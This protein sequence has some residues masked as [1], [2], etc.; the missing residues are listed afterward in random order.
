MEQQ[1]TLSDAD[2]EAIVS[3]LEVRITQK[4]YLNVGKGIFHII[5]KYALI[6]A[7]SIA[8][9]GSFKGFK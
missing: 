1:R 2:V 7:L 9:Y 5:W 8:A 3:C 6:A 4:F